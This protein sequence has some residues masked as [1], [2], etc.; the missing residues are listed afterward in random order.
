MLVRCLIIFM[1]DSLLI[2]AI[3]EEEYEALRRG[4][5]VCY[6]VPFPCME[7]LIHLGYEK[8]VS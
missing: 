4:R 1:G 3:W 2:S 8:L 6:H 5:G 7:L